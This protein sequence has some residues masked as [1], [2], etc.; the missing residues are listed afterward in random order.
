MLDGEE[1]DQLRALMSM[2]G[3]LDVMRPKIENRLR[4]KIKS[5]MMFPSERPETEREDAALRGA[6]AELEWMLVSWQNEITVHDHNRQL[7]DLAAQQQTEANG[8][9]VPNGQTG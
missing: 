3:W 7:D 1:I 8:V 2:K 4:V 6:I 9:P 5:L